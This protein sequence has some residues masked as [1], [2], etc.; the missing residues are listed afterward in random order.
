MYLGKNQAIC[1]RE[2]GS[3]TIHVRPIKIKID[4]IGQKFELK[5]NW[6]SKLDMTVDSNAEDPNRI[7][8]YSF[9]GREING[10]KLTVL[11]RDLKLAPTR[12]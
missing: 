5:Q 7:D 3:E 9:I 8:V 4:G 6:L 11:K 12:Q 10:E 1:Y 2:E